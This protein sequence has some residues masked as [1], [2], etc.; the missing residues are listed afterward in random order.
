MRNATTVLGIIRKRGERGLPLENVYRQ[1]YNPDLYLCAYGR[2]YANKGAMTPGTTG[3]TADGMALAKI[4]SL[5]T[6]LR[7]ERYRWSPVKRAYVPK[8]SGKLR[9]LGLPSWSDKLLGDVIR[10]ILDAYYDPQFSERSHG[11]RPGRGCHTALRTI[12]QGWRGAKWF[13]EG[14]IAACFERLD[15]GVLVGILR[16]KIHDNRFLRLVERMLQAGYLEDWRWH[17]TLSGTPQGHIASPVLSNCYLDRLDQFVET[18]LLPQYNRGDSRRRNG[19]HTRLREMAQRR[20]KRGAHAEATALI[21]QSRRLPSV[22]PNDPDFRR[23]RYLRYADDFLLGFDGP[24]H[25][26]EE[27]TRHLGAFLRDHLK[28]ELSAEK[29]LIT[30]A[31]TQRARFLG[32]EIVTRWANHHLD[33]SGRRSLNG[34]IGLRVP[35]DV[36]TR[37]CRDHSK[38]GKPIHRGVLIHDSDYAIVAMYQ[39]RYR[40]LVQYYALAENIAWFHRLHWV[41]LTSLLKTLAGKH[42]TTVTKMWRKYASSVETEHGRLTCLQVTVPRGDKTPLVARFG[43]I[44]L[45]R[46]LWAILIDR[47]TPILRGRNELVKRLLAQRCELCG[48]EEDIEVHHLRKLAD[49]KRRGRADRPA[50]MIRMSALRR[51]TLVTCRSCHTAIHHGTLTARIPT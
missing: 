44:P 15:H 41:M 37:H 4:T 2:L 45:R 19:A 43:G 21:K 40:G 47:T 49:L 8:K 5:I 22:D 11:F 27:I 36:L 18:T 48:N 13:I 35:Q 32:Y 25:E 38:K 34:S 42:K 46:E 14:D 12:Q 10:S 3:E 39:A 6:A 30:H 23:L 17:A 31:R 29:T 9:P 1:L 50:W 51:K 20:R 28:L 33:A 24:K 7:T 26:A 16:E